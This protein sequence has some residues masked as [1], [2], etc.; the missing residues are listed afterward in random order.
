MI[1]LAFKIDKLD[2]ATH[3]PPYY[4]FGWQ[5]LICNFF[6]YIYS[7]IFHFISYM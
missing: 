4:I 7:F 1:I 6:K 2:F 5:T 3:L